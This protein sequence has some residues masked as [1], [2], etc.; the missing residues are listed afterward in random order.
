MRIGLWVLIVALFL[1]GCGGGGIRRMATITSDPPCAKVWMNGSYR[2]ETPVEIPYEWNWYYD[3]RLEKDGYNP[4]VI[5]E[6]FY[7]PLQHK[8]PL[9]LF[10]EAMPFKSNEYQWRHYVLTPTIPV[11]QPKQEQPRKKQSEPKAP[12][13]QE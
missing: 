2:G 7:A 12:S 1:A 5:R 8:I 4:Y 10:V 6:R 11:D 13:V 9:D 3:F